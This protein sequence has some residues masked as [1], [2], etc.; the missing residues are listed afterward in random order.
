[1]RNAIGTRY[2]LTLQAD[3]R[4]VHGVVSAVGAAIR[5]LS[6]DDVALT[7]DVADDE[8]APYFCGKVLIP[9]PNRVRDGRWTHAGHTCQLE[10]N[11]PVHHT[12]LH[13]LL[14]TTAHQ[15]VARSRSS[16]TLGA[17]VAPSDGYPFRLDTQV[18]YRLV[19]NGLLATHTIRNAGPTRAAVALGAH[20]FLTIG[21][22]PTETLTLTVDGTH[23]IDVDH[24][25]IPVGDTVVDG[26]RW[27]LRAGR[28]IADLDLDD[29]WCVSGE[30]VHTLRAPDGR[31]VSLWADDHFGFVHVFITR[32]FPTASG[33]LTA[34]ALEPMTAPANALNS[35]V[36]LRWLRPGESF[37]ASWA[38]RFDVETR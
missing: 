26:S 33:M 7:P 14:C 6:V 10:V 4:W 36:G 11:D 27:D 37:S 32:E 2:E 18:T 19:P 5:Q 3:G 24:R 8:P 29:S 23:H 30:S 20:P 12:A 34:V 21:D 38:I 13:G 17:T 15:P 35:G 25:R 28:Q 1:M 22:V 31:S 16:V 9:W